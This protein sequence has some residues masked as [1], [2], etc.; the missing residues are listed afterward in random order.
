[1]LT[2]AQHL[3]KKLMLIES[4]I[5]LSPHIIG[6]EIRSL[7]RWPLF[8]QNP[9]LP[10]QEKLHLCPNIIY[11]TTKITKPTK[12][13]TTVQQKMVHCL[14]ILYAQRKY[15][16]SLPSD[17][18]KEPTISIPSLSLLILFDGSINSKTFL[19]TTWIELPPNLLSSI[20][21]SSWSNYFSNN[22]T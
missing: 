15:N 6:Q 12:P 10:P 3:Q 1:M 22:V 8:F 17:H 14:I 7:D 20:A 19:D 2:I 13:N 11:W 16:I 9:T 4:F 5:S 21:F 18:Y